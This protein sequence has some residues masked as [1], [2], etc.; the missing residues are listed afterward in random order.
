MTGLGARLKSLTRVLLG[1]SRIAR[2]KSYHVKSLLVFRFE[3]L[4]R[5]QERSQPLEHHINVPH[6][7]RALNDCGEKLLLEK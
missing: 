2:L 7:T 6:D 4:I 1:H 5:C 3:T